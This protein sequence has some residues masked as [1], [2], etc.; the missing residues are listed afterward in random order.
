MEFD[1]NLSREEAEREALR[2]VVESEENNGV[3]SHR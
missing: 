3:G 1:G 2:L